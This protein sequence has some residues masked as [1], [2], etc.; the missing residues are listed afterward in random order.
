LA[1][2][3]HAEIGQPYRC[4]PVV[5]L[6]GWFIEPMDAATKAIAWVLTPPALLKWIPKDPVRLQ[7]EDI[8]RI[9][10]AISRIARRRLTADLE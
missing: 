8:R 10:G 4:Q 7:Q 5:V 9:E 1:E 6:P 2:N 3:L